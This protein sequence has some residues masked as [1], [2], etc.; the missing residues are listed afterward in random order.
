MNKFLTLVFLGLLLVIL[1]FSTQTTRRAATA[2]RAVPASY[3]GLP[4]T[5]FP[6]GHKTLDS[7]RSR[8]VLVANQR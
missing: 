6:K 8:R 7:Y 1:H 5:A 2:R 3:A 4:A